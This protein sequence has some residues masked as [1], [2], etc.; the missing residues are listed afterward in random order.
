MFVNRLFLKGFAGCAAFCLRE[1][2]PLLWPTGV[3]RFF[4]FLCGSGNRKGLANMLRTK[5]SCAEKVG[6]F[7]RLLL[8]FRVVSPLIGKT[9]WAPEAVQG[10][11]VFCARVFFFFS[12]AVFHPERTK[13]PNQLITKGGLPPRPATSQREGLR[14]TPPPTPNRSRGGWDPSLV[15]RGSSSLP[16]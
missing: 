15:Q 9:A 13:A 14:L 7:R 1:M 16:G 2:G 8:G 3:L 6:P 12:R 10:F 11:T 4:L 5:F